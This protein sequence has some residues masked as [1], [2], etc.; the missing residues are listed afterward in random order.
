MIIRYCKDDGTLIK[1]IQIDAEEEK[2]LSVEMADIVEW[3]QNFIK[4]RARQEIDRVVEAALD[5]KSRM[6]SD[7][8]KQAIKE[9][10]D[11][12]GLLVVRPKDLPMEL[13]KEIVKRA[14]MTKKN[15]NVLG[16]NWVKNCFHLPLFDTH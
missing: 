11:K 10:I 6:L 16:A 7:S 15:H 12:T 5:P 14:K 2:A 4:H 8:D 9:A 3:H 1:E 13:K